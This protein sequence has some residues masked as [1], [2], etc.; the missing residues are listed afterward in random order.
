GQEVPGG[1]FVRQQDQVRVTRQGAMLEAVVEHERVEPEAATGL[2]R[3]LRAALPGHHRPGEAP[4]QHDRLV[5]AVLW[6]HQWR[7]PLPDHHDT[8]ATLAIAAC[9][10]ADPAPATGERPR[11]PQRRGRLAGAPDGEI[12]NAQHAR[13]HPGLAQPARV[14][15]PIAQPARGTVG[16]RCRDE[17]GRAGA[18]ARRAR[19]PGARAGR[20]EM[21]LHAVAARGAVPPA[22]RPSMIARW[23]ASAPSPASIAIRARRPISAAEPGSASSPP[24]AAA[25]S[26][27]E[28]TRIPP[29]AARIRSTASAAGAACGPTS[30]GRPAR[31]A[32]STLCPPTGTRLPP[33]KAALP[34]A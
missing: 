20:R 22:N 9:D 8:A 15:E 29:P 31:A 34:S 27:A 30:T 7:P 4:R 16:E 32:S 3:R 17:G 1:P 6:R 25:S 26:A 21:P 18:P 2:G 19:P 10:D 33:T 14:V 23:R 13:R 28:R 12:S 24:T 11:E 5:T